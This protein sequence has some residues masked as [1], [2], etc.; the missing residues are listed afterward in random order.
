MAGG[1]VHRGRGRDLGLMEADAGSCSGA[2]QA[3]PAGEE[4]QDKVSPGGRAPLRSRQSPDSHYLVLPR[5]LLRDEPVAD[6]DRVEMVEAEAGRRPGAEFRLL[7]QSLPQ[8]GMEGLVLVGGDKDESTAKLLRGQARLDQETYTIPRSESLELP[9]LGVSVLPGCLS[10]EAG[11][12]PA[13]C[14]GDAEYQAVDNT[15]LR[16]ARGWPDQL[17][18]VLLLTA[19]RSSE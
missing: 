9:D 7:L 1:G 19:A 13:T 3:A 10:G 11:R 12:T 2:N 5:V 6:L 15:D 14:E 17:P 8:G 16:R 18:R 4:A